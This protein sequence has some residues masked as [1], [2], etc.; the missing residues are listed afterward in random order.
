MSHIVRIMAAGS[1]VRTNMRSREHLLWALQEVDSLI[2]Q[3]F[4]EAQPIA[5]TRYRGEEVITTQAKAHIIVTC[6]D[7]TP[8]CTPELGFILREDGYY[9]LVSDGKL[10]A[11][12]QRLEQRYAYH[13]TRDLLDQQG[14]ELVEEQ[15]EPDQAVRLVLR[16]TV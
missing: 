8:N 2:V 14:F 16:R 11:W 6:D 13:A 4:D 7:G 1:A 3:S 10:P 12:T 9:G 15:E 5:I